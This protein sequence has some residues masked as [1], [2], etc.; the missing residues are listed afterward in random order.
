[1]ILATLWIQVYWNYKNYQAGK[2]QLINDVQTS[3]DNAVDHYFTQLAT[4]DSFT[5]INDSLIF[6]K[7]PG[8]QQKIVFKDSVPCTQDIQEINSSRGYTILKSEFSD[9]INL[10]VTIID[11]SRHKETEAI[12]GILNA[13]NDP[14]SQLSSKIMI[15]LTEDHISLQR[16]D[17]LFANELNRKKISVE[18]GLSHL[19]RFLE[20]EEIRPDINKKATL[21]TTAESPYFFYR[22][23]LKAHFTNVTLAVL[24]KNYIGLFLSFLLVTSTVSCLLYLLKIIRQQKQLAEVKNDLISNI[25]HEFKTPIATIGAAMEGIQAFNSENDSQKNLRYSRISSE[26]VEKL[27]GMVEKLLETATLDS[28]KLSLNFEQENLVELLQ[29]AI[30]KETFTLENK[31][32]TFENSEE[33]INYSIDVFHFENAINNIIDNALKYGGDKISVGIKGLQNHV[34]ITISDNGT[35]LSEAHKKQIFE[36]FYRVPTGNTH[37]VKGF[38]IGLYYSKQIIEKHKGSL[39]LN[40]SSLTTFKIILPNGG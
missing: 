6:S 25:T 27:N 13:T 28:K 3:L 11:S 14:I 24:K 31:T 18:Y 37:D 15:S 21:E 38:G 12:I 22:D 17:S 19:G 16:I 23:N 30:K 40:I 7:R 4:K 36:K 26:Q 20:K 29:K 39:S 1:V 34:E 9:S 32:I 33:L 10:N 5:F 8:F 2:Q 35:S